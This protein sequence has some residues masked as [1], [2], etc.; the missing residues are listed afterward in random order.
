MHDVTI[1]RLIDAVRAGDVEAVEAMLTSRPE[2][3][4]M[5]V[6]ESDEHQALHHAVL[7][8]QPAIVR[9]L[10]RH[11][12]DP[13]AGIWPHRDATTPLT[14]A[15][16]REDDEIVAI[17]RAE[18]ARRLPSG[19]VSH[20]AER[21]HVLDAFRRS[22]EDGLIALLEADRSL[23]NAADSRRGTML[24]LASGYLLERVVSWLLEHGADPTA[25]TPTGGTA[26]GAVGGM[27]NT[28]TPDWAARTDRIGEMLLRY[29]AEITPGWAVRSG[30]LEKLRELHA[31]FAAARARYPSMEH[32][33]SMAVA[34]RRPDVVQLLLD[35]GF[36]AD[37]RHRPDH[38]E[39]SVDI[40]G[41][42]LRSA[43]ILGDVTIAR[44]LLEHGATPQTN[45]YAASSA[46]YEAYARN[47]SEMVQLLER[48]GGTA[49]PV[50]LA[51]LRFTER[52]RQALD[53][54]ARSN[55]SGYAS[56]A[57]GVLQAAG[58]TGNVDLLRAA[59]AHID[60]PRGDTRWHW[61]LMRVLG[62]HASH[63][64]EQYVSCLR[65]LLER[66]GADVRGP[67]GRTLLHDVAGAWPR[68]ASMEPGDRIAF[69][70][71]L[72][73]CGAPVDARDDLLQSTPL[74]WACRWGRPEL[75]RLL[76]ERG[77]DPTEAT[78]EPWA[79][80]RAWAH[81]SGNREILEMLG[82]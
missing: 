47:Q 42:P 64:R 10:M 41:E 32:L 73:E 22:D 80:P 9:L 81:K 31:D 29:G 17:I 76:I 2:L 77:A 19:N 37:E 68:G 56:S 12:A 65:A 50:D 30:N 67:F 20:D 14:L 23:I 33:V 7:E 66:S 51:Y 58:D 3:A 6:A 36:D 38:I 43:V 62:K 15:R 78:A 61:M 35:L 39:P 52:A 55:E 48:F 1:G 5:H 11:G 70:T 57:P 8:R 79:S 54:E 82:A 49:A 40:W 26:L 71:T 45:V 16:D 63:D 27:V 59:L 60:W 74:G 13:H 34:A 18:E 44:M 46:I 53:D 4:R 25:R 21:A 72:L 69:A 28:D 75:V 24:M